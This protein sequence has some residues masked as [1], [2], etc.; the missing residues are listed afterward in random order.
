MKGRTTLAVA[1]RLSTIQAADRILVME[2][3]RIVEEGTHGEL[4]ATQGAY[5]ALHAAQSL[6]PAAGPGD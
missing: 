1:H 2:A 6:T 5:A 4:L 3:G